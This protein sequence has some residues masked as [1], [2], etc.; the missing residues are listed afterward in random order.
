VK[1]FKITKSS[2]LSWIKRLDQSIE[3][4]QALQ[5]KNVLKSHIPNG[6][7]FLAFGMRSRVKVQTRDLKIC[8]SSTRNSTLL[9]V[10][11]SRLSE[12]LPRTK[13]IKALA[14]L[15]DGAITHQKPQI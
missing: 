12:R 14:Q 6:K 13:F 1:Y 8:S 9:N 10:S 3:A 4:L 7:L 11:G 5:R 2:L 15:E